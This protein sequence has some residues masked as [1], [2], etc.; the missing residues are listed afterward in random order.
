LEPLGSIASTLGLRYPNV[1]LDEM[2]KMLFDVHAHDSI[3]GCNSDDTNQEIVNRLTKVI[4]MADGCLNLLKKQ[5]T[6]AISRNL[7]NDSI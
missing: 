5:I 3:G 6:E 1:W 7:N 2:W 4:R